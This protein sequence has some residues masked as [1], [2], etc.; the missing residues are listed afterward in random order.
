LIDKTLGNIGMIT[1]VDDFAGNIVLTVLYKG[2]ELL[3]P[4]NENLL[5]DSDESQKTITLQLPEGLI[6]I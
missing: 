1:N 3:I 6:E 2:E 5:V 4:Y